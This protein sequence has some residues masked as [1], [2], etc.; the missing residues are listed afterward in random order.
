MPFHDLQSFV[1]ALEQAGELRRIAVEVDPRLEIAEIYDRVVKREGPALLFEKVRG[2]AFP[3]LINPLGSPRR[4]ELALG[5]HPGEIGAA[6]LELAAA[7]Q[8]PQP[9]R[10]WQQRGTIREVLWSMRARR[11]RRAPVHEVVEA[12]DLS[13]LPVQTCWPGDGG[14]F[15]TF[16]L[17]ITKDPESG[18]RN[19]GVYRLHVYD[20]KTTG[21]HWQIHKGGGFHYN[22]AERL[23]VPL[24]VAVV[25]GADPYLLMAAITA[26]PEGMDEIA[27]SGLLRRA[28]CKL[29]RCKSIDL[30][31]PAEAEIV[32]EGV[33][34][35]LERR[36]EGPF[37][38][39]FGHYSHAADFPVFHV[40]TL[41]RR[42]RPLYLSAT[43]GKPPQEDKHLGNA[44]QESVG[45][46]IK[47]IHPEIA[48]LWAYFETGF[49]NLLVMS[50]DA[51]YYKES[52]RTALALMGTGQLSLTKCGVLVD[53]GVNVRD[54]DAVL[55]AIRDNFDPAADFLLLPGVPQDTLDF[56]SFKMNLG[57]KMVLDATSGPAP[58]L[59][60]T[61]GA[62]AAA[63]AA[64]AGGEP[65]GLGEGFGGLVVAEDE[66]R[67]ATPAAALDPVA[68]D[69]RIVGHALLQDCL[70]VVQVEGD[71]RSVVEKLVQAPLGPVRIVAVVSPDV[72]LD[73]RD[74]L[75]WGI[76]TR[77][78]CARD[79][80]FTS[81][82]HRGP[83]TTCHGVLGIDATF[84]PGYPAPLEMS[85]EVVATVDRRWGEYGID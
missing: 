71:G 37:G 12:A 7:A 82:R 69:R 75:L 77:F 55:R 29:V 83:W 51:R 13:R 47:L 56:T 57:S 52:M 66:G 61:P 84:K 33:V 5:R 62:D 43:V 38:D 32:L 67:G 74:L 58:T 35:P 70:L 24:E 68:L 65:P 40:R 10:L 22:K 44:V 18:E 60:G 81:V 25:I 53:G 48:D 19:V 42:R 28:P 26:L 54:F 72:P 21:M 3:L 39:H 80:V 30:E 9:R 79:V 50:M 16:G 49:H 76:F 23:G 15:I 4:I 59:H 11:V 14:P 45:P 20:S 27:F 73:D 34:P 78:D 2:A 1:A 46:L 6:L 17:V 31:V 64:A 85:P 8:P 36:R 41:T 63:V